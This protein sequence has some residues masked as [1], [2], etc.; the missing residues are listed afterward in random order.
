[1]RFLTSDFFHLTSSPVLLIHGLTLFEY[2]FEF[3]K[4]F[5][6]LGFTAGSIIPLCSVHVTA[7]SMIP[8]CM[9]HQSLW[10]R[11]ATNF[12]EYPGEWS[13][14]QFFFLCK[15][16]TQLHMTQR[17]HW[18][19]CDFGPYIRSALATFKGNIYWKHIHRQI[20]LYFIYN[21]HTKNM[22]VN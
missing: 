4:K 19:R 21:L 8:L 13:E 12:V 20:V 15:N 11:C 22:R 18:Q 5:N 10:H 2:S 6:R 1:M 17:Y 7:L 3:A 9:S 14:V 16:L